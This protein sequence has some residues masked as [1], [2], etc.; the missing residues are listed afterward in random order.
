MQ[1]RLLLRAPVAAPLAALLLAAAL[2]LLATALLLLAPA[3]RLAHA[4]AGTGA[5]PSSYP[6]TRAQA[7]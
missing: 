3:P 1:K 4:P 6:A 7:E 2:L 5:V